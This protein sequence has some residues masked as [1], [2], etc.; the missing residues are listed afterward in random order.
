MTDQH[1]TE[2]QPGS[3]PQ[4]GPAGWGSP[5][6]SRRPG[7]RRSVPSRP[8]DAGPGSWCSPAP[9]S[10]RLAIVAFVVIAAISDD[11]PTVKQAAPTTPP[12]TTA[13]QGNIGEQPEETTPETTEASGVWTGASATAL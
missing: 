8:S 12:V 4:S 1:P 3:G 7:R 5:A 11:S 9:A 10:A 6:T 2:P 13:P